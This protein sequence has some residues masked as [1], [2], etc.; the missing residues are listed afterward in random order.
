MVNKYCQIKIGDYSC[1]II[2]SIFLSIKITTQHWSYMERSLCMK[3]Y[4]NDRSTVF[5]PQ[6]RGWA[7]PVFTIQYRFRCST[8]A[9]EEV[10]VKGLNTLFSFII[11]YYQW[12]IHLV[13]TNS[14]YF[15][16]NEKMPQYYSQELWWKYLG[17]PLRYHLDINS[18]AL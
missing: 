5:Y 15:I 16:F 1:V 11:I 10:A 18:I 17:C 8:I 12:N 2:C 14:K 9:L 13:D 6:W 4:K 7:I 3:T